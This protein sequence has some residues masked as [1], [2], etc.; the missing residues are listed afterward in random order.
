VGKVVVKSRAAV[1]RPSSHYKRAA[2]DRGALT[3]SSAG[4][5]FSQLHLLTTVKMKGYKNTLRH[6]WCCQLWR[7]DVEQSEGQ[8]DVPEQ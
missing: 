1:T 7:E 2:P 8:S 6:E 3:Y 5:L 4:L